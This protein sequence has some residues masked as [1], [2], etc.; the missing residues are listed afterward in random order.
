MPFPL[1][2]AGLMAGAS[3]VG[4]AAKFYSQYK[5]RELYNY[6]KN[7]YERYV[8]NW[9]K[10]NPGRRM[11]YPELNAPGKIRA[12]DTGISQSYASSIG[13][14]SHLA[15]NLAGGY[16]YAR[17]SGLFGKVPSRTSRWL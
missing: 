8:R 7:A 17:S 2:A 5:Q 12:L 16:G 1:V 11:R 4:S 15:G 9:E 13:T 6:Q 14:A 3:V 10:A